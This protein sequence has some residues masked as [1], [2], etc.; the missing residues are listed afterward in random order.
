V[1][2]PLG[3]K[4]LGDSFKRF[5]DSEQDGPSSNAA[6][7][8]RKTGGNPFFAIQFHHGDGRGRAVRNRSGRRQNWSGTWARIR[9]KAATPT[10][11][12]SYGGGS[13]ALARSYQKSIKS[14]SLLGKN[15]TP[16]FATLTLV[17]GGKNRGGV[18]AGTSGG[19]VHAGMIFRMEGFLRVSTT[20]SGGGVLRLIP[21][22]RARGGTPL[23]G[24]AA[25]IGGRRPVGAKEHISKLCVV[26]QLDRG[27]ERI[28]LREKD[29]SG[30]PN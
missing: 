29:A 19:S 15:A 24:R 5:A 3:P 8:T 18:H 27:A 10:T 4:D 14:T 13:E 30:S 11:C 26:N 9:A 16:E 17:H 28:D 20:S 22:T 25:S 12:G 2:A 23:I 1:L 7:C 6:E 21:G